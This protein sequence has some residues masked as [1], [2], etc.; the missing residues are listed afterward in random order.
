LGGETRELDQVLDEVYDWICDFIESDHFG[1]LGA[2]HQDWAEEI[3]L[4]FAEYMHSY[5]G[6]R[7][8]E[9]DERQVEVCCL[10][11]IPQKLAAEE[12]YYRSIAPVLTVFFRFLGEAELL[13]KGLALSRRVQRL[14]ARI[15]DNAVDPRCWGASKT[16]AMAAVRAGI[17]LTDAAEMDRFMVAY[18]KRLAGKFERAAPA[19]RPEDK[20]GARRR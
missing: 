1:R 5:H 8:E 20:G 17:D 13:A 9:W 15:H 3:L 10:E 4:T 7:P 2:E 11:T 19:G 18:K 16:F 6:Q 12:S 14:G